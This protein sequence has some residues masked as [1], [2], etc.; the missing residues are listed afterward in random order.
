[1]VSAENRT[2]LYVAVPVYFALLGLATYWAYRRMENMNH[3]GVSDK[4]RHDMRR[5]WNSWSV[6]H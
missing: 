6:W 1:M 4:V 3:Q 5:P 2:G